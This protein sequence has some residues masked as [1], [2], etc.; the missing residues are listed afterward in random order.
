MITVLGRSPKEAK[1]GERF[2]DLQAGQF[3]TSVMDWLVDDVFTGTDGV[4]YAHVSCVTD[5]SRRKTLSVAVLG[6]RRRF[7]R[8]AG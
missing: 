6:D 8:V 3:G 7:A 1:P 5:A 2:R 4:A